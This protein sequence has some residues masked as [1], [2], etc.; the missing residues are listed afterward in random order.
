MKRFDFILGLLFLTFLAVVANPPIV[1]QTDFTKDSAEWN[2]KFPVPTWNFN[3]TVYETAVTDLSIDDYKFNGAYGKFNAGAGNMA[4]PLYIENMTD[5]RRW[6]FRLG[7]DGSSYLELPTLS[8]VGRFTVFC[9]N[10]NLSQEVAL[11]IQRKVND[12]WQTLKTVYLPPHLNQN[13]ELQKEEFL[14]INEPVQL[15]LVGDNQDIHIYELRVHAYDPAYPTEKPLRIILIPDPQNYAEIPDL[16]KVYGNIAAWINSMADDV[17]FVINQGDLT[18]SNNPSDWT[19]AAGALNLLE[20]RNIPFTFC[21]GN[22][23]MGK[24]GDSRITTYMNAYLPYSRYSRHA[25]F[26]GT[27]EIGKVDN[28]WHVFSRGD[29]KFL[30][31]SLEYLPRNKILDWANTVISA[32]PKHNVIINTHSFLNSD[33]NLRTGIPQEGLKAT[34]EETPNN[35]DGIWDKCVKKHNNIL[36]VFSGHVLGDGAGYRVT[37]GEKG[38]TVYQFIANYQ[39]GVQGATQSQR[40]G[41][42][43]IFD[44]E[45]EHKR[46]TI[47][48]YSDYQK[49]YDTRTDHVYYYTDVNFIKDGPAQQPMVEPTDILSENIS[50]LKWEKEL[51][52][53]NPSYTTPATGSSNAYV[54]LNDVA[55]YFDKYKLSGGIEASAVLSCASTE[56]IQHNHNNHAVAFRFTNN[57]SGVFELPEVPRAGVLTLHVKN[58]NGEKTTKLAVEKLEEGTWKAITSL[59]LLPGNAL[60]TSCD[61]IIT[62]PV[63][64][65]KPVKLRLRNTGTY[66]I[67][68]YQI[69]LGGELENISAL[70]ALPTGNISIHGHTISLADAPNQHL[71]IFNIAG[72]KIKEIKRTSDFETITLPQKGAYIVHLLNG[73]QTMTRKVIIQ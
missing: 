4:Q 16:H 8:S 10:A 35:G 7:S 32:H 43:R 42:N 22:H 48:T 51:K 14:N 12:T 60:R 25:S 21:A 19:V 9:K 38:N 28:T 31:L 52:R 37:K 13:Y 68:L 17:K 36:F 26:G 53:L 5:L 6:A 56:N 57:T 44:I 70:Q 18:Q 61:E 39:G 55:Y 40:N 64:I 59:E 69:S 15:R 47:R 58:D 2:T 62:Y 67:N 11:H 54:N 49:R 66:F 65:D 27:Y 45:P 63:N 30:I 29:Y 33:N 1:L 46:F 71:R 23:D 34:G 20:G 50:S 72:V 41:M 24:H 73:K 3:N